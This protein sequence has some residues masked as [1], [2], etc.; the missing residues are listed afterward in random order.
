MG[1]SLNPDNFPRTF[2]E[3]SDI[4][5]LIVDYEIFDKMWTTL[6]KWQ[7]PRK[8]QDLGGEEGKWARERRKELYW[9]WFVP[10]EIRYKGLSFTNLLEPIIYP[11]IGLMPFKNY[12]C[13]QSLPVVRFRDAYTVHGIMRS[14]TIRTVSVK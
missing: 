4:D 3:N 6:L 2:S 5:V 8:G 11:L 14:C 7:Y 13:T 1:F 10:S 9:G 12:L